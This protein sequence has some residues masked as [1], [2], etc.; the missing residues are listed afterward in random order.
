MLA[1]DIGS[2]ESA[3]RHFDLPVDWLHLE[4]AEMEEPDV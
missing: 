2:C 3:L 1:R 4:S